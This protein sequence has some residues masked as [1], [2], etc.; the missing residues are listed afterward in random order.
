MKAEQAKAE[1]AD[2]Q[3]QGRLGAAQ[4]DWQAKLAEGQA[5]WQQ[6]RAAAEQAW[7]EAKAQAEQQWKQQLDS[8]Q[9]AHRSGL[10]HRPQHLLHQTVLKLALH[11]A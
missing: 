3:W 1:Q 9:H 7:R 8:I 6:D 10:A 4:G 11:H 2:K 5:Q